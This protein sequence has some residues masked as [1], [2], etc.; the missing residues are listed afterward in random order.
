MSYKNIKTQSKNSIGIVTISREKEKN[1]LDIETSREIYESMVEFDNNNSINCIVIE[2]NSKIFSPGAD[3]KEL[4]V[5][6]SNL[7]KSKEL[8]N[9]RAPVLLLSGTKDKVVRP[10]RMREFQQMLEAGGTKVTFAPVPVGHGGALEAAKGRAALSA[11][12][13]RSDVTQP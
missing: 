2:G 12:I 7:A 4:N 10:E 1:S 13:A 3:I 11:F 6:D 5:M 9:A 8:F